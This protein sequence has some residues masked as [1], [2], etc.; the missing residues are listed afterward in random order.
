ML[1][2]SHFYFTG[3]DKADR[4]EV[5][6]VDYGTALINPWADRI[7]QLGGKLQVNTPVGDLKID[8]DNGRLTHVIDDE[9]NQYDHVILATDLPATK[10]ILEST[11][12][13]NHEHEPEN[14]RDLYQS[15]G[16]C[17]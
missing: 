1:M 16:E 11:I 17:R 7:T 2:F 14:C 6:I 4:R 15:Q 10:K 9:T 8:P 12:K 5:T 13:S 3:D